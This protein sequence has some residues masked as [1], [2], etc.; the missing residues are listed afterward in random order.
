MTLIQV[1][2]GAVEMFLLVTLTGVLVTLTALF[3]LLELMIISVN[4]VCLY[5]VRQSGQIFTCSI[6]LTIRQLRQ[7]PRKIC[8][9]S[10]NGQVQEPIIATIEPLPPDIEI[11]LPSPPRA[12]VSTFEYPI[13]NHS[14]KAQNE[15]GRS[16]QSGEIQS[17]EIESEESQMEEIQSEENQSNAVGE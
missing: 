5:L 2:T 12:F 3:S 17:E 1:I 13:D 14:E 16:H 8:P 10:T 6:G 11:N 7:I 9:S 4:P 15:D